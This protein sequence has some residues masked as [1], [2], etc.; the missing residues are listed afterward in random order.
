M[1][2]FLRRDNKRPCLTHIFDDDK[3]ACDD[4]EHDE[5]RFIRQG[6]KISLVSCKNCL[7]KLGAIVEKEMREVLNNL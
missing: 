5:F 2:Y 4:L 7:R 6:I 1:T 3:C